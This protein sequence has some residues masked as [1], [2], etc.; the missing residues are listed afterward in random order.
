LFDNFIVAPGYR[1]FKDIVEVTWKA[2]TVG[3]VKANNDGSVQAGLASCGGI[4]RD[5]RGTFHGAFAC[6]LGDVSVSE[7]ELTGI[8]MAMEYAVAHS[9]HNL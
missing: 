2:P 6:N 5:Y 8:L 4:F 7:A 9:W 1:R 3:W